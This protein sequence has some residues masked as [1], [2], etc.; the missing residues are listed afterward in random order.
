LQD[1][2]Y[3][4]VTQ[5]II[6]ECN[7][8]ECSSANSGDRYEAYLGWPIAVGSPGDIHGIFSPESNTLAMTC[9][10]SGCGDGTL[11]YG[12]FSNGTPFKIQADVYTGDAGQP[13]S[14]QPVDIVGPEAINYYIRGDL[15]DSMSYAKALVSLWNGYS[16]DGTGGGDTWHIGQV[17]FVM[18][19]LGLDTSNATITTAYGTETYS[20]VF[21]QME[22]E[23]WAIQ[24]AFG[25]TGGCLPN[26]YVQSRPG[27]AIVGTGGVDAENQD[28]ALLP[29]SYTVVSMVRSDF[30]T[31]PM[32]GATSGHFFKEENGQIRPSASISPI[33]FT[34]VRSTV[35]YPSTIA[36]VLS[37]GFSPSTKSKVG[38]L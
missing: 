2:G 13:S 27:G 10:T 34:P 5:A 22:N 38:G 8:L 24:S 31:Y 25:C 7:Y 33:A 28:A 30:G 6:K 21:Q 37:S 16:V 32:P 26:S 1:F 29:F 12:K 36:T 9:S 23:L 17:M 3:S 15:T 14:N 19:V 11:A 18:R 35:A 4:S 20:Q